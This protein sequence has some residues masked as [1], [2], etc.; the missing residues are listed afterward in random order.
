MH[1]CRV[2]TDL[3]RIAMSLVR[4]AQSI[5]PKASSRHM[6]FYTGLTVLL[7]LVALSGGLRAQVLD[8]TIDRDDE[9]FSYFSQPTDVIGVM[10]APAAT[11]VTPEGYL[12][13][14]FGELLFFTGDPPVP[15]Q[16]RVK[17]L[18]R[19]YLPVIEFRFLKLCVSYQLTM[20]AATLD[21]T[22][23][24]TLVN[25][26]RVKLRNETAA[27]TTA[28]FAT[29]VRYQNEINNSVALGDN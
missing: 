22:P 26:V 24:G 8:P 17:T 12:F 23:V 19:D 4:R 14:G 21:G 5:S 7:T 10:D 18:L 27:P 15:V 2:K 29:G 6:T 9:P 16:Q 25:F 13:T 3:H 20:F 1:G 11:L 28:H